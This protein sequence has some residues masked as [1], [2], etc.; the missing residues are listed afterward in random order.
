MC[1]LMFVYVAGVHGEEGVDLFSTYDVPG[2]IR[3]LTY[4]LKWV[5]LK[6]GSGK[7]VLGR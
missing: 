1:L 6:L 4:V 3:H 2:S 7:K 5:I